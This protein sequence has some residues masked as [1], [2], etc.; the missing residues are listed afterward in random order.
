MSYAAGD[1]GKGP[2]K[3]PGK[4]AGKDRWR[5]NPMGSCGPSALGIRVGCL[6]DANVFVYGFAFAFGFEFRRWGCPRTND[7][8]AAASAPARAPARASARAPTRAPAKTQARV[9]GRAPAR[10]IQGPKGTGKDPE[11]AVGCTFSGLRGP[12]LPSVSQFGTS[13][14]Q[15]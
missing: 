10:A 4:G 1:P 5:S 14:G 7:C 12:E 8:T 9:L 2:D 15:N 11:V 6:A 3:G 13:E